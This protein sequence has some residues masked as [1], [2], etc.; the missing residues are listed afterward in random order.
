MIRDFDAQTKEKA[1]GRTRVLLLDGHNSHYTLPIL[2]YARANNI[3]I[4]GYP[5]HCTHVLQGLDVVCFA[6]MKHQFHNEIQKFENLH[7]R[8]VTKNDF[9]GVFGRAFLCAFTE[10]T[11][12]AAFMATGVHPFNPDAITEKQMKPS[13]PTSTKGMFPMPQTSP[14]RAIIN[15][16]GS[17]PPTAFDLSPTTHSGPG[18]SPSQTTPASIGLRKR[19]PNIDWDLDETPSKRTR[20]LYGALAST[21]TGSL[22]L[23]KTRLTSSYKL[24]QPVLEAAPEL[25]QPDWSLLSKTPP[26]AY[27]TREMLE[28]QN[29]ELTEH[30]RRSQKII[31]ARELIDERQSAQLVIQH[32]EM[33]KL[34]QSLHEKEKRKKNDRTVLFPGG[35]GR[36]LTGDDFTQLLQEQTQRKED[37]AAQKA[38]RIEGREAQRLARV[39]LEAEWKETKAKH[40]QA[41]EAWRTSC[42]QLRQDGVRAKD[43][44]AKPKCPRK[45]Q[46]VVAEPESLPEEG[47]EQELSGDDSE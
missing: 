41:V 8:C 32:A 12:K 33:T 11:V 21:S 24:M 17:Q 44:P 34:S 6:K 15:T 1:A 31:R 7:K 43:L 3:I 22:L 27:Q 25:P 47:G 30:L 9:A 40:Q 10:E 29:Q 13:L 4:L 35:F 14:V 20:R 18:A 38:Q 28:Q 2:E 36:H 26:R 39:A 45:P 42:E 37:E 46:S 5:P 16:M 23:S 19:D